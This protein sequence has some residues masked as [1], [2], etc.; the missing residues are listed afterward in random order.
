MAGELRPI[1]GESYATVAGRNTSANNERNCIWSSSNQNF[2]ADWMRSLSLIWFRCLAF[3]QN[4]TRPSL[5]F[6][7]KVWW[8]VNCHG[9]FSV[10]NSAQ[11]V[12][13]NIAVM[14]FPF[15]VCAS[16]LARHYCKMGCAEML[17]CCKLSSNFLK[18]KSLWCDQHTEFTP[19]KKVLLFLER[20]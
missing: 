15:V 4:V 14:E 17:S 20:R 16:E 9:K 19:L 10:I 8:Q 12:S 2:L 5:G 18:F 13:G 11:V 7:F 6:S 1:R 3:M